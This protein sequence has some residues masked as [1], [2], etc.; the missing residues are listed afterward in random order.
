MIRET[1][2][3][4]G[5]RKFSASS[6]LRPRSPPRS[7][8]RRANFKHVRRLSKNSTR[9]SAGRKASWLMAFPRRPRRSGEG[10]TRSHRAVAKQ[11]R[12]SSA[13]KPPYAR[14]RSSSTLRTATCPNA[15]RSSRDATRSWLNANGPSSK[16]QRR[17]RP[18]WPPGTAS[19]CRRSRQHAALVEKIQVLNAELA[20][21][22]RTALSK[23]SKSRFAASPSKGTRP[24]T[25]SLKTL[26][27]TPTLTASKGALRWKRLA[28]NTPG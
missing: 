26:A 8:K 2:V 19:L 18:D 4:R 16:K 24:L 28:A 6:R 5:E 22:R 17:P 23:C 1:E 10:R 11:T 27:A 12:R 3:N 7:R 9:S 14:A 20:E 25:R 15:P 13:A 21:T